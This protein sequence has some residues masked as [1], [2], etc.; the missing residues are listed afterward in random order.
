MQLK[1]SLEASLEGNKLT[2]VLIGLV[3]VLSLCYVA[4]EWTEKNV[5]VAQQNQGDVIEEE[6]MDNVL[7]TQEENTP[8]P[9]APEPEQI[10]QDL[11]SLVV[12][13]D[14]KEVA[15]IV[16]KEEEEPIIEIQGPTQEIKEE[17]E[18]E[19]VV[20]VI[21][22]KN[23]EFPGGQTE[24]MKYLAQNIKYPVIAA[25]NGIQGRVVCQFVVNKDG[26]IVDVQVVRGVD[27]ALD[28]EAIRVIK[29]MPKWK[30]G[31]Q[32]GQAVRVKF[33]LPVNFKLQ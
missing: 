32:R 23:P 22:E 9:P 20:F 18:V 26:S 13:E 29:S 2:Y 31:Q 33:T 17:E 3:F 5:Q 27:P 15:D 8:P 7:S 10:Q 24:L 6:E 30:P 25:E 19:D 12:V 21:V 1:K 16:I 11:E 28:K 14:E 4:V